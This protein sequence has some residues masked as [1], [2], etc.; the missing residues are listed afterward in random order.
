MQMNRLP[1]AQYGITQA[2][3]DTFLSSHDFSPAPATEYI[4]L[5]GLCDVH[6]HFREPG[7]SYKETIASGSSSAA[8]GGYTAVCTMPN[9]MPAPDCFNGLSVQLAAIEKDGRLRIVPYGTITVGSQ[10][11]ILSHMEELAPY[12][13]AFSD[14]GQ[15]VQSEEM[16]KQAMLRAK[17][18]GKMIV[19]H[20]E[21]TALRN[22]GYIHDGHY[23][24]VHAHRAISSASEFAQLERDLALVRKTG[25]RYHACHISTKESVAL[26]RAAKQEGL[27]VSC[28]TAPHYLLLCEE[29]LQDEG[30]FKMNPPLRTKQDRSALLDGILDGTID[31][32][33]T[34]HAPH[35]DAEKARGLADSAMGIVGLECAFAVLYTELVRSGILSLE[36]L[37][38][39]MSVRPRKRFG[40]DTK[41]D[42]TV[43]DVGV[44]YTIDPVNFLSMGH[45]T[46]FAGMQVF[47]KCLLTVAREKIIYREANV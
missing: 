27:D 5:P 15:G 13:C 30:R 16:M 3:V 24:K 6:V 44:P 37:I 17:S 35:T 20:C 19:A 11:T 2:Y 42:F 39:L 10:G 21:D 1:L 18:L 26:V 9:L 8:H 7:F 4:V 45:A 28:E 34:D 29:D 31:M 38:D 36:K 41:Q 32:I 22:G 46:P 43:F 12:V 23:A 33:A 40:I 47:G 25:C 14:D